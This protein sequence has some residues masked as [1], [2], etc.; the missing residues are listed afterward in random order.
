[1]RLVRHQVSFQEL[2]ALARG[3]SGGA[4]A[5]RLADSQ[6]SARLLLLWG[7]MDAARQARHPQAE[8]T[9]RAYVLLAGLQRDHPA[10]AESVLGHP[11]VGAWALSALRG[12]RGGRPDEADPAALA[13]VAAAVMIRAKVGGSVAVPA[14]GG[15]VMLPSLGRADL[16]APSETVLV[17][18]TGA[19]A[20]LASAGVVVAI[21]AEVHRDAYGWQALRPLTASVEGV[22]IQVVIDDLDPYRLPGAAVGGRLGAGEAACWQSLFAEAWDLLV[23]HHWRA[24]DEIRSI[25][26]ALVPLAE[27]SSGQQSATSWET[28][29]HV[30]TSRPVSSV[31][32]A[33][34]LVHEVQHAKLA[35]LLDVVRLVREDGGRRYYAPWREDPRPIGGLLQG[36]YAHL[37]VSGFWRRQRHRERGASAVRAH[38]EFAR[39]RAGT[40]QVTRTLLGSGGLTEAGEVFVTGMLDT[41]RA[42]EAEPVP[43]P[44]ILRARRDAEHHRV[45]WRMR[46]HADL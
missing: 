24:A 22:T 20:E 27:P 33:V 36:A 41:L 38:T 13:A 29:G 12:L 19:G 43:G 9:R 10:E 37:G 16:T 4:M 25:T 7:V 1:M 46:N 31:R 15:T 21:P 34:T 11:A 18:S 30:G 44:A 45:R 42:W 35:A 2:D 6:L 14:D 8:S 40:L 26:R 28:F 5:R 32:L 39:W 23:R 17:R 3:S